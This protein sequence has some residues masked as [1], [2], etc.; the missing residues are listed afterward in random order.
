MK[1]L[2]LSRGPN[3]GNM[4]VGKA[5]TPQFEHNFKRF[6]A[7]RMPSLCKRTAKTVFLL[8]SRPRKQPC[9]CS[10]LLTHN[11]CTDPGLVRLRSSRFGLLSERPCSN[12]WSCLVSAPLRQREIRISGYFWSRLLPHSHSHWGEVKIIG[13]ISSR[14]MH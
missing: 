5:L 1:K 10:G 11:G 3:P 4:H 7:P 2:C 14:W 6:Q 12:R 8:H 13:Y 9:I